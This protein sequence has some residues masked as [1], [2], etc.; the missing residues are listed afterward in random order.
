MRTPALSCTNSAAVTKATTS[1]RTQGERCK[2][3]EL[4]LPYMLQAVFR[5]KPTERGGLIRVQSFATRDGRQ[6]L[7]SLAQQRDKPP[8]VQLSRTHREACP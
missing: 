8:A 5:P 7:S 1:S 6:L 2:C 3:T 4:P